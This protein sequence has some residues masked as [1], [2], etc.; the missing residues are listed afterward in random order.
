MRRWRNGGRSDDGN[1]LFGPERPGA[2]AVDWIPT[3][4]DLIR[5][6]G[7]STG[8]QTPHAGPRPTR[9]Q[10]LTSALPR[11]RRPYRG[12]ERQRRATGGGPFAMAVPLSM[13]RVGR[14][15]PA[16]RSLGGAGRARIW[17]PRRGPRPA[18]DRPGRAS[19]RRAHRPPG[20]RRPLPRPALQIRKTDPRNELND[21]SIFPVEPRQIV[22]KVTIDPEKT[23]ARRPRGAAGRIDR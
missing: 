15:R 10:T 11:K 7:R 6:H 13:G 22:A 1:A 5:A 12:D 17:R 23:R 2:R 20:A 19:R 14:R 21:G 3:N 8:R 9:R 4:A 18:R 16:R